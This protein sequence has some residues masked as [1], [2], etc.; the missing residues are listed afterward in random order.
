MNVKDDWVKD[1]TIEMIPEQ[2][3]DLARVI[4]ID[5]L[6][7]LSRIMGGYNTYIP[8]EDYFTRTLRDTL[9]R[10]EYNGY[11]CKYLATRYDLSEARI[12]NILAEGKTME[13]QM[14][15]FM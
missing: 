1:I 13:G 15:L 3:R 2:Y 4:G 7:K 9:I 10:K 14:N 11:N 6:L 8:K 5:N 12:R